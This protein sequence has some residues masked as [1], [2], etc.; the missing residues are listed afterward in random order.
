MN[1]EHDIPIRRRPDGSIDIE[2]YADRAGHLR[3]AA[4]REEPVRWVHYLGRALTR[5]AEA[6]HMPQ[7]PNSSRRGR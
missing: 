3:R 5:L 1:L 2:F 6:A 7:T 4:L